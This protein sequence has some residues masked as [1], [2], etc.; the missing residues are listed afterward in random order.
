MTKQEIRDVLKKHGYTVIAKSWY[1]GDPSEKSVIFNAY[2]EQGTCYR[3]FV[4]WGG[5]YARLQML[6]DIVI[7]DATDIKWF[8]EVWS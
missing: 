8:K 6:S 5:K 3:I 7:H 4:N 1:F 2:D